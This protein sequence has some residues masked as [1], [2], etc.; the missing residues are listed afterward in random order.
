VTEWYKGEHPANNL[1]YWGLDYPPLTAYHSLLM[2]KIGVAFQPHSFE[3]LDSRGAEDAA[4]KT[5]MRMSV[6]ISDVL[7]Y[8]PGVILFL[9]SSRNHQPVTRA[10]L[11]FVLMQPA[12][13]LI[14]HAHFQYNGV[15]LGLVAL[16]AALLE[17]GFLGELLGSALFVLALN[18]KHMA[19][20]YAPAFFVVLLS[21]HTRLSAPVQ[22][23]MRIA[24]IGITVI[25]TFVLLWLPFL[26]QED[27]GLQVVHRLFPLARG[28]FEDKVAN[29]WCVLGPVFRF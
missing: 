29:A 11:L 12:L 2:G 25:A 3:L 10:A 23:L 7:T 8:I 5:F 15:C 4:T 14:D 18:F 27:R 24:L 16:A 28:I 9:S 19:L 22:S 21:R 13:L 26:L 20:Y 1:S 6:V 17:G